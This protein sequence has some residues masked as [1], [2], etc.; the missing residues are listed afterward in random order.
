MQ[1]RNVKNIKISRLYLIIINKVFKKERIIEISN[2]E[3]Y[4]KFIL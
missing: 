4:I 2:I 1:T 3:N